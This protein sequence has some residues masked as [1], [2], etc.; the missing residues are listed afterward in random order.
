MAE[1][2]SQVGGKKIEGSIMLS[3]AKMKE[4]ST[5]FRPSAQHMEVQRGGPK[6]IHPVFQM[7]SSFT[8][9]IPWFWQFCAETRRGFNVVRMT[10]GREMLEQV[11]SSERSR[12]SGR[13]TERPQGPDT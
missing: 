5:V 1:A 13:R 10:Q 3:T 4:T 7:V 8:V 12:T 2:F 6:Q 9:W 11:S